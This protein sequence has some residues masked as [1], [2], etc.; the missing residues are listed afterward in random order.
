[1]VLKLTL[2]VDTRDGYASDREEIKHA[3]EATG[4]IFGHG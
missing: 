1:M 4:L 2:L 3:F